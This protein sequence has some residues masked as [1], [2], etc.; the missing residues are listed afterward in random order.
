EEEAGRR[1]VVPTAVGGRPL[2]RVERAVDLD[3]AHLPARVLEL[4]ASGQIRRIEDAAPAGV[5]P[6]G[7]P[8][9]DVPHA[10]HRLPGPFPGGPPGAAQPPR[11]GDRGGCSISGAGA[12]PG[13]SS[14]NGR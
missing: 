13:R 11:S 10:A 2:E 9:T 3:G 5:A 4:A 8:D 6:P 12:C 14:A 7:D 1:L